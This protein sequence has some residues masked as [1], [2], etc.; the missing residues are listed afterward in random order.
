MHFWNK[1]QWCWFFLAPL[2]W[3][4]SPSPSFSSFS[5]DLYT[6]APIKYNTICPNTY[7]IM[8]YSITKIYAIKDGFIDIYVIGSLCHS[9]GLGSVT[10]TY[11]T[12]ESYA[13]SHY[14]MRAY[15]TH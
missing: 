14:A 3:A 5:H 13:P 6:L 2:L 12:K 1:V 15:V 9:L 11:V 4:P 10:T 7:V 8:T